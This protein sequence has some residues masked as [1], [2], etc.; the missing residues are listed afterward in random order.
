MTSPGTVTLCWP[1]PSDATEFLRLRAEYNRQGWLPDASRDAL[2]DLVRDA[3][4]VKDGSEEGE[5]DGAY[6]SR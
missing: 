1:D 4:V 2:L 5:R 3:E 6:S